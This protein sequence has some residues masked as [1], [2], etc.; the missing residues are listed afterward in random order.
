MVFHGGQLLPAVGE[1]CWTLLH[2]PTTRPAV[3]AKR[4]EMVHVHQVGQ[5]G[6]LDEWMSMMDSR[7]RSLQ[8]PEELG[9]IVRARVAKRRAAR[10]KNTVLVL[11]LQ[12]AL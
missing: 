1:G 10:P 8:Q 12:S 11:P 4:K 7:L 2:K 9:A 5:A 6:G 3:R